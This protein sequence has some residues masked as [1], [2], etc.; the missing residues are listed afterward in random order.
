MES[1]GNGVGRAVLS[2]KLK[3]TG[4]CAALALLLTMSL[5]G[6]AP[7]PLNLVVVSLDT[8]RADHLGVYG[9][10]RPTSPALDA[11]AA[12]GVVFDDVM[13]Q[14]PTT[15]PAH[16][17]LLTG[18]YPH[19]HGVYRNGQKL[20]EHFDTLGSVLGDRGYATGA[21]VSGL[22]LIDELSGLGRSFDAYDDEIENRRRNGQIT[23]DRAL[24]WLETQSDEPFFLFVHL[25]DAHGPYRPPEDLAEEFASD[26]RGPWS[27]RIPRYQRLID[28][29]T[30][31]IVTDLR[32]YIDRYDAS[33]R[34]ADN[35]L[36]RLLEQLDL[37]RTVV[38]VVTDHGESLDENVNA[39]LDHGSL[40][41]QPQIRLAGVLHAPGVE[42][43]RISGLTGMVDFAPTVLGV[44]GHTDALPNIQGRDLSANLEDGT[45]GKRAEF[46]TCGMTSTVETH[47]GYKADESRLGVAVRKGDL[48]L[49]SYP[50]KGGG[51]VLFLHDLSADADETSM[52]RADPDDPQ[53]AELVDLLNRWNRQRQ[54]PFR[55]EEPA[56]EFREKL[57]SLGYVF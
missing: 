32:Y 43:S 16:Y 39:P 15:A 2:R 26:E 38:L 13:G 46:A 40:L 19:A 11:L 5:T 12:E 6:C 36:G 10:D 23:V 20:P 49:I 48:K 54:E 30:G 47:V 56:D 8:T 35:Q 57:E 45:A 29:N 34:H 14:M 9:Y 22:P 28:P 3:R 44:M 50:T 55:G 41:V 42:P 17:S 27:E 21:F 4:L 24:A 52:E 18:L 1:D 53:V 31:G 33:I 7:E 25:F 37:E 51:E